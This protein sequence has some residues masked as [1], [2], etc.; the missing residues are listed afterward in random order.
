MAS[1]PD[2]VIKDLRQN[3]YAPVYFLQGEETFYI[4]LI[5]DYIEKNCL[6]E[7]EKSFNQ[8]ILYGKDSNLSTILL[9]AKKFPMMAERQV[10]IVKEAQELG[11]LGREEGIK[12]LEAYI[13]N[14]L[15]STVLVFCHKYKTLDGRKSLAKTVDKHCVLVTSKKIYDSKLPEW[16]NTYYSGKGIKIT[17]KAALML[18]ENIGNNLDRI[19]NETEKLLINLKDK[20]EVT[21]DLI[22]Q[23]IGISKEYNA[24]ELQNALLKKDVMKANRIVQYFG[25]DPRNNSI[26]PVIAAL[27]NF[28]TKLI[29]VH[30]SEDKSDAG[31]AKVL[32]VNPYF[33]KDYTTGAR[34]YP[35]GKLIQ[36][37]HALRE[38]DLRTKGVNHTGIT[39][40][41]IL[42]E[43]V[44]KI[45]H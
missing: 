35:P 29:L 23:Y 1:T 45:L 31:L 7:S 10:V 25:A 16:I 11:D 2:A 4:D 20:K 5:S 27:F 33:I 41:M 30:A 3:K 39:D 36:I 18:A 21:E 19:A 37:I 22:E 38:A 24:F 17:P 44:F 28:F 34:A 40:E 32:E 14:P 43:L 26:I 42:K 9:N 15:P 12:M 8:T 13:G 6:S